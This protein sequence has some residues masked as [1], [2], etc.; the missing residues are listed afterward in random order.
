MPWVRLDEHFADHPKIVRAGP[1]AMALHVAALCYCNRFLTDG[2]VPASKV[3]T[4]LD[5]TEG[6]KNGALDA[7]V[8]VELWDAAPGGYVIHDY[9]DYQPSKQRVK[10]ERDNKKAA[11]QAGGQAR[12][13]ASAQAKRQAESKP[14]SVSGSGSK[15]E[16]SGKPSSH[17]ADVDFETFW[18]LYP[19]RNGKRLYKAKA[20]KIWRR[21]TD[22]DRAAALIGAKFYAKA[23]S[24]GLQ[25]AAA[26]AFRWLRDEAWTDWQEPAKADQQRTGKQDPRDRPSPY[27]P[28]PEATPEPACEHSDPMCSECR[29][30]NIAR[31]RRELDAAGV[32]A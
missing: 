8:N 28:A 24:D 2:F 9:L 12:A 10:Q 1:L 3:R 6:Q 27:R 15:T 5:L 18:N 11:G 7:L 30:E 21:L 13:K 31:L 29:L 14:G 16:T 23:C 32:G 26:D 25:L 4:L 19:R 20:L 22:P 17:P